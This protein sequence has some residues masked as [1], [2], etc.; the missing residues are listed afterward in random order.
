[1]RCYFMRNGH[2][3]AVEV[4][5]EGSDDKAAIKQGS[6]LFVAR[7]RQGFEGFEIWDRERVVFRYPEEDGLTGPTSGN[8]KPSRVPPSRGGGKSSLPLHP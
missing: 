6:A 1:M 3:A 8:G 4:L 5:E 2:I 7:L